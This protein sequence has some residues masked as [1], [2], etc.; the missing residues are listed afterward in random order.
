[1]IRI[2]DNSYTDYEK[3]CLINL[4]N[5]M[6]L[7]RNTHCVYYTVGCDNCTMKRLCADLNAT[8]EWMEENYEKD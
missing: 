1:M 2:L 4:W 8:Y 6:L 5:N 7:E 3:R